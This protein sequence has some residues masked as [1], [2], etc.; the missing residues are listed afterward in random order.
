VC[1]H[2]ET[3]EQESIVQTFP[4]SQFLGVPPWQAPSAQVPPVAHAPSQGAVLFVCVQVFVVGSAQTS[5]VQ[6]L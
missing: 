2:P 4:S 1:V 6:G 5:S 3:D